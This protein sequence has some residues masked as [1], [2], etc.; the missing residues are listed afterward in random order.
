MNAMIMRQGTTDL[1]GEAASLVDLT[2]VAT[3]QVR[4][5]AAKSGRDA[6]LCE[7]AVAEQALADAQHLPQ[8]LFREAAN[9]RPVADAEIMAARDAAPEMQLVVDFRRRLVEEI[10]TAR[11]RAAEAA[12]RRARDDAHVPLLD[13]AIER[14][15]AAVERA[16]R[17]R[18]TPGRLA[19]AAEISAAKVEFDTATARL[20]GYVAA[21]SS[22]LSAYTPIGWQT[23]PFAEAHAWRYYRSEVSPRHAGS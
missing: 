9:G 19:D 4:L 3:A 14:R 21:N 5:D 2:F 12:V 16:H 17:A 11:V 1:S 23:T 13:V 18:A 6:A 8:K 7:L 22:L 10:W 20:I 15:M